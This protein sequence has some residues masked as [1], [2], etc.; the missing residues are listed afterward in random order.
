[1][2]YYISDLHLFH[3]AI[4]EKAGRPF[5]SIYEMN[6]TII[7]NWKKTVHK[8]DK[9]MILGDLGL[10]HQKE[11]AKI[12]KSLPGHKTLITGNHD[13]YNLE[14]EPLRKAFEKISVYEQIEDQ[15]RKVV[16]FHYKIS[17]WNGYYRGHYHVHGHIHN[18][19][20]GDFPLI[21]KEKNS[22]NCNVE[23]TGYRPVTLDE[24]ISIQQ[25]TY[26]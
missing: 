9:V 17:E 21:D 22:F 5:Y 24:L 4:I 23:A 16:L 12:M 25:K 6:H 19:P 7:M 2:I 26:A 8:D 14:Y 10:Y 3:K 15:G 11:T 20:G 18:I 1:M 13:I